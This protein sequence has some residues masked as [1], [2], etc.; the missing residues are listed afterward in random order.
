M[1]P[2]LENRIMSN[3]MLFLD[4][5][6]QNVGQGYNNYSSLFYSIPSNVN[7]WYAYA[8]PFKQLCN[9]TSVSGVTVMSG[10]YVNGTYTPVGSGHLAAI[11]HYDGVVYFNTPLPSTTTIS[12]NYAIKEFSI[13]ITDQQ[14][15]KLLFETKYVSNN[16][17]NQTLSGLPLDTKTSPIIFLMLQNNYSIPFGFHRINNAQTSIRAIVIADTEYQRIAACGLLQ[18]VNQYYLPMVSGLPF[19]VLGNITGTN[20]NYTGL[21]QDPTYSPWIQKAKGV[22]INQKGDYQNIYK[23]M[24]MVDFVIS[25]VTQN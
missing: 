17:F 19:D 5:R 22:D 16:R 12:G 20:Y 1:L 24:G 10:V 11:N 4:N 14:E 25:T 13:E 23:K 18:T 8:A 6:L 2:A 15:W 21:G 7:G 3:L 9:D